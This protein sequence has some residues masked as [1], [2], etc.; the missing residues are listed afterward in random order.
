MC[1]ESTRVEDTGFFIPHPM[2]PAIT[3]CSS[4]TSVA[5][6]N[7]RARITWGRKVI[8]WFIL[9]GNSFIAEEVRR[10]E[11]SQRPQKNTAHWLFPHDLP[12]TFSHSPGLGMYP[13]IVL[14]TMVWAQSPQSPTRKCPSDLPTGQSDLY[15]SS[16]WVTTGLC[17]VNNWC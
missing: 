2:S 10:Q 15:K 16:V 8:I 9:P 3:V 17:Q 13:R 14:P 7:N 6:I 12:L 11:L 5:M 1:T 4:V